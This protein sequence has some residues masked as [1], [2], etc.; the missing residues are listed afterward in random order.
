M[1]VRLAERLPPIFLIKLRFADL[2]I[3]RGSRTGELPLVSIPMPTALRRFL[4]SVVRFEA[5]SYFCTPD[6]ASHTLQTSTS[7]I[8][9]A[10]IPSVA[11]GNVA[12]RHPVDLLGVAVC[13]LVDQAD[14][15]TAVVF[16]VRSLLSHLSDRMQSSRA[17]P[18]AVGWAR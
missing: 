16:E 7:T 10:M 15:G 2:T 5:L 13:H 11:I 4:R 12:F 6:E 18:R 9:K 17:A 14:D 8:V 1:A 3:E